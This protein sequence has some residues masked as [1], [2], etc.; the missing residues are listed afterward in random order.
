[1][2]VMSIVAPADVNVSLGPTPVS[3]VV[4]GDV[5]V[6]GL[7]AALHDIFSVRYPTPLGAK[8]ELYHSSRLSMNRGRRDAVPPKARHWTKHQRTK[9]EVSGGYL[10]LAPLI[11]KI[12]RERVK[13]FHAVLRLEVRLYASNYP[14]IQLFDPSGIMAT[15]TQDTRSLAMN[16]F[17]DDFELILVATSK[18]G[19]RSNIQSTCASCSRRWPRETEDGRTWMV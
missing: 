1:M 15:S 17:R 7:D 8:K 11:G 14:I 9:G 3:V 4:S 2:P 12:R 13:V 6:T 18:Q 10:C 16:I 19:K 5:C